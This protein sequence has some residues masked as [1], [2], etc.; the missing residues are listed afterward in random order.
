MISNDVKDGLSAL[1]IYRNKDEVEKGFDNLKNEQDCKRL[2]IHSERAMQ[3]RLFVQ[4]LS[5]I[6]SSEIRNIMHDKKLTDDHTQPEIINELKLLRRVYLPG[7]RKPVYTELTKFQ[8][9]I[10]KAFDMDVSP[11][12]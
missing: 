1:E 12:V 6:L 11:Y 4:F 5:L 8:K 3:G 9:E 10:Y 2:R 7:K